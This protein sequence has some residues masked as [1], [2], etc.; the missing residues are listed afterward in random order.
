MKL[1]RNKLHDISKPGAFVRMGHRSACVACRR[2][3]WAKYNRSARGRKRTAYQTQV[4]R[5]LDESYTARRAIEQRRWRARHPGSAARERARKQAAAA[6]LPG[7]PQYAASGIL[8][9]LKGAV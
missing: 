2:A 4:A 9:A 7:V 3:A 5:V 6:A 8:R 1:C